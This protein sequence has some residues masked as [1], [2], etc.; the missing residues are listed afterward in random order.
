MVCLPISFS[1]K[2]QET[3]GDVTYGELAEYINKNVKKEAFLTNEKPQNPIVATSEEF[4][5]SWKSV[6]MK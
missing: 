4:A 3:Q 5:K 1:K 6:N 2:L